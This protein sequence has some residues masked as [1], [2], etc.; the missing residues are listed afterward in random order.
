MSSASAEPYP[1]LRAFLGGWFNQDFDL[2]GETLEE[3]VSAYNAASSRA[4][5]QG[6]RSDIE[7]F[8]QD[9]RD[10]LDDAFARTFRPDVDPH[11]WGMTTRE[12]LA[13]IRDLLKT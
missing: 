5:A 2:A 6:V 7:A 10:D 11:G 9:A 1:H 3:I 13:R 12:W 4:D 8:M